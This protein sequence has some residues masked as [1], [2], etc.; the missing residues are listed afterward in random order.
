MA[1]ALWYELVLAVQTGVKALGLTA[2]GVLIP[3]GQILARKLP[4]DR[5]ATLPLIL[6]C[7]GGADQV[8]DG[9]FEDTEVIYPVLVVHAAAS[10]QDLSL[11]N[12]PLLWRQKILDMAVEWEATIRPN[13]TTGEISQV[14]IE[15]QVPVDLSLFRDANMDIGALLIKFR[16]LRGRNR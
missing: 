8:V 12:D 3:A 13:V 4:S 1:N 5:Q 10:N 7:L 14:E 11:A 9:D 2:D 15:T 6:C 16:T